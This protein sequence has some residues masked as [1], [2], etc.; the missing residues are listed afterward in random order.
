MDDISSIAQCMLLGDDEFNLKSLGSYAEE[1]IGYL[2]L[3][4]FQG[5]AER[6]GY[7][8][9]SVNNPALEIEQN[10]MLTLGEAKK[11][12]PDVSKRAAT[13]FEPLVEFWEE[14]PAGILA[15]VSFPFLYSH[16]ACLQVELLVVSHGQSKF[17]AYDGVRLWPDV[18]SKTFEPENSLS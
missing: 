15:T 16:D 7:A 8:A 17:L 6:F 1:I 4:D 10:L 3:N 12:G 2:K 13:D 18:P 9:V 14:H 11:L 5:I